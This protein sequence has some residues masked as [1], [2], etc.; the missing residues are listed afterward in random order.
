[1][2]G[3][4]ARPTR[5]LPRL[6]TPGNFGKAFEPSGR[7]VGWHKLSRSLP[8]RST[9][10]S[11]RPKI[12]NRA[13]AVI[14][15][16][17]RIPATGKIVTFK[18]LGS[19]G[20]CLAWAACDK[21]QAIGLRHRTRVRP[22]S[23]FLAWRDRLTVNLYRSRTELLRVTRALPII[24]PMKGQHGFSIIELMGVM[25]IAGLLLSVGLPS[26]Q[27][28][29]TG[30]RMTSQLNMMSSSLA[31]A[32]SEAAK[33]NRRVVLCPANTTGTA[34]VADAVT[35]TEF[36]GGWLTFIDRKGAISQVDAAAPGVDPCATD[37]TDDCILSVVPAL[38]PAGSTLMANTTLGDFMY[39]TGSGTSSEV[40]RFVLCD[41]RDHD[42]DPAKAI[43]A[44][45]IVISTTGRASVVAAEDIPGKEMKCTPPF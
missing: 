25:V 30:N 26:F 14:P 24:T 17:F 37:S 12:S 13:R 11:P 18:T 32:R 34:C 22:R 35:G 44:K 23:Q 21:S 4:F 38:T 42:A 1:M 20:Y 41:K 16:E 40:V 36:N 3:K 8:L 33:V 28:L 15:G 27:G 6:L 29:I 7:A 19:S 5:F 43:H 2:P 9:A 45:A 39:F 10:T 31:L